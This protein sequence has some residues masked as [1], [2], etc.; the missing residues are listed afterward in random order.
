MAATFKIHY[1]HFF[2]I[3]LHSLSFTV[4]MWPWEGILNIFHIFFQT[5]GLFTYCDSFGFKPLDVYQD[6]LYNFVLLF[7]CTSNVKPRFPDCYD[8]YNLKVWQ[9]NH[10][11]VPNGH[12]LSCFMICMYE[13]Y[14]SSL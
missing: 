5:S 1:W 4:Y 7:C 2:S 8:E 14:L 10:L 13:L 12:I 6:V 3:S 11:N 9:I